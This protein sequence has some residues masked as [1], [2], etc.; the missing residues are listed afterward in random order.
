VA[1][2]RADSVRLGQGVAEVAGDHPVG[3]VWRLSVRK[4]AG[5]DGV[6][7]EEVLELSRMDT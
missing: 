5:R 4:G 1:G 3:C 6:M 7:G 2:R